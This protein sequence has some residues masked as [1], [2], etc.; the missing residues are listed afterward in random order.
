MK[1]G[2][3]TSG[4]G[5]NQEIGVKKAG[6]TRWSSHYGTL[7]SIVSLFSSM[8]DVLDMIEED[9]TSSE[10]RGDAKLLLKC[11]QSFEFIFILHLMKKVLSI[12]HEL[13]QALQ[14]SDQDIVNAMKLVKM[15]KQ[16]LQTIRDSGWDSLLD[17]VS[18]FCEHHEVVIPNMDDTYQTFKKS[19][20][21][22]EKVS[23]LHYFQVQFFYQVID[24]QLQE[25][26]N[27]FSEVNTELLLCVA[28]LNLR[29]S[30][31]AFD[32]KNLIRLAEFYPSKFSPVQLL[33]LDSQL[34]NYIVDVCSEDAFYELEGIGDLS[35]K[36]VETRRHIVYPLVYLLLKLS[37]IL[38]VA[39]ATA[40][41]AFSAMKIIKT[42]LR[43]RM[44]D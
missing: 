32:K 42:Q 12:T 25:L 44:G 22:S 33:E 18:L 40:E 43:N 2:K 41:R 31:S 21:N 8:I 6:D 29:D 1:V 11:M 10:Q 14:R 19:K 37:L 16:K 28:C 4:R 30:F 9:G 7:L 34:E 26:N 27:R 3:I 13:S 35:I 36:M 5:L 20:R 24:R 39:T 23:N 38:L 15:S 17:E